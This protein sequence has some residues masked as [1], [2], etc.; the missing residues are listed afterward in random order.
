M[1]KLLVGPAK[2]NQFLVDNPGS[3]RAAWTFR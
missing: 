2:R 3:R 1:K